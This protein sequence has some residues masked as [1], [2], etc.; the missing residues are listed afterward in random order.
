[1]GPKLRSRVV[2]LVLWCMAKLVLMLVFIVRVMNEI[3]LLMA[4][5]MA[6]LDIKNPNLQNCHVL[7][8]AGTSVAGLS[9]WGENW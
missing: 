5:I 9:C 3:V 7:E 8:G 1:M 2:D 4:L 6:L